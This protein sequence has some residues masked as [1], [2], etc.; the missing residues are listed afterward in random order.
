MG[1]MLKIT[2]KRLFREAFVV[3]FFL[4]L[5]TIMADESA[6]Y[7]ISIE[8]FANQVELPGSVWERLLNDLNSTSSQKKISALKILAKKRRVW[9]S[10]IWAVFPELLKSHDKKV[11]TLSLRA[12]TKQNSLPDDVLTQLN[13]LFDRDEIW[14][15][16]L[17]LKILK[18][19]KKLSRFFAEKLL[20]GLETSHPKLKVETIRTMSYH[21][22]LLAVSIKK[23]LSFLKLQDPKI[24]EAVLFACGRYKNW[25]NEIWLSVYETLK[26]VTPKNQ[27]NALKIIKKQTMWPIYVR[28]Y[29]PSLLQQDVPK[30]VIIHALKALTPQKQW[31][32]DIWDAVTI[33]LT[34]PQPD[35]RIAAAKAV[36]K[37]KSW[38]E[39]T[40]NLIESTFMRKATTEE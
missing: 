27:K 37:Q 3:S 2:K 13:N 28:Q 5:S 22:A 30:D 34:S 31:L 11:L 39:N 35:I 9:S 20:V 12:L 32:Q 16:I 18:K 7:K 6:Q 1:T 38:P 10:D 4:S 8:I 19:Q 14:I 29:F 15:K 23:I 17:V 40:R 24:T 25:D 26:T 33:L 21:P 36:S